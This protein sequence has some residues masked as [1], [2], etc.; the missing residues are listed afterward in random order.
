MPNSLALLVKSLIC[1]EPPLNTSENCIPALP[2]KFA[3]TVAR[4]DSEPNCTMP[5]AVSFKISSKLLKVP[6]VFFKST[7]K[8]LNISACVFKP[9]PA[10]PIDL[11]NFS[12]PFCVCSTVEPDSIAAN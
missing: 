2:N 9:L 4:S 3:N 6:S 12:K 11:A 8:S 5:S 10:S 7:F 1:S